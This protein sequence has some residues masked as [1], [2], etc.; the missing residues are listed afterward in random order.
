MGIVFAF[1]LISFLMNFLAQFWEPAKHLS[2]LNVMTYYQPAKILST[3][4]FPVNHVVI[5]GI[6]GA[7]FWLTGCEILARRNITTT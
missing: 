3:N 2:S 4:E 5:L 7:V 1:V 6:V